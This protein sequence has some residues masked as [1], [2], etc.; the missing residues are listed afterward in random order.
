MKL[1]LMILLLSFS[2]TGC[3]KTPVQQGNLLKQKDIDE[4]KPGMTKKQVAIILGTP[5]IADPFNNDRWDYINTSKVK[6]KYK[7][8]KK[9]TIYFDNDELVR[10]EGNYFPQDNADS[11]TD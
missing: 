10:T 3:Y 4:V 9:F 7:K 1:L 6:G 2:L 5:A 11:L 8:L